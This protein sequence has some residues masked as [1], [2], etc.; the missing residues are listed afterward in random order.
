LCQGCLKNPALSLAKQYLSFKKYFT[1]L[2]SGY[3]SSHI[4]FI[5]N[6]KY[7]ETF[8][9]RLYVM[10]N[11][12]IREVANLECRHFPLNCG[13]S[14]KQYF[15]PILFTT[16]KKYQKSCISQQ[17]MCCHLIFLN[18]GLRT[19]HYLFPVWLSFPTQLFTL[20]AGEL[21]RTWHLMVLLVM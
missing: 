16:F 1:H 2:V 14:L 21:Y 9:L 11:S 12:D 4:Q 17:Y 20:G 5:G 3:K 15:H 19:F 7:G 8:C 10:F 18:S 13:L 6:N